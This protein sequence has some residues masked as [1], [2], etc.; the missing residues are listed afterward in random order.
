V[1]KAKAKAGKVF[2]PDYTSI[3]HSFSGGAGAVISTADDLATWIRALT[4]GGVFDPKYQR[5]WLD[6]L[7]L[8]D[9]SNK[10]GMEYGYGISKLK[11]GAENMMYFHGG[12]T[13]GYNSFMGYDPNNKVTLIVWTNLTV[14]IDEKPTANSLMLK[15]LDRIYSTS[16]LPSKVRS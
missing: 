15:I 10:A 14:S 4:T 8:E 3:N 13:A 11:W 12:E 2:P 5:Q 1:F 6:S 9:P 7:R 16:P